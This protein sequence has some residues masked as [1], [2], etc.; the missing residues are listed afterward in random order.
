MQRNTLKGIKIVIEEQNVK[1]T[2]DKI[3]NLLRDKWELERKV[4]VGEHA[5]M[6]LEELDK[7]LNNCYTKLCNNWDCTKE[8][9][10]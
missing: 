7:K 5:R 3:F 10:Q 8:A 6:E 9:K 4:K 2:E 1:Q